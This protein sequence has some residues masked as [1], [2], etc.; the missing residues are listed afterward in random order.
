MLKMRRYLTVLIIVCFASSLL[1]S[2]EFSSVETYESLH[3]TE[4]S[5]S[6]FSV[7]DSSV[8][9]SQET[10]DIYESLPDVNTSEYESSED[11]DPIPEDTV[12]SF[13]AC[14][15]NIIHPSVFYD[16]I[17]RAAKANGTKASYKDLHNAE[18]DF[19]PIYEHVAA[20]IE[21]A[22]IAYI[23]Q[24]TLVG[25][26]SGKIIG[27]PCFNS[28]QAIAD[29]VID[30]G[31]DVVNVAHNHMLDSG[32]TKYLDNCNNVFESKG[33]EVI[34]YYPDSESTKNITVIERE[35]IKVAFLAY[36]YGTNGIKLPS[37]SKAVI[38]YFNKELLKTQVAIA[39][40][41]ADITIVSCHWGVEN[42]YNPNSMQKEYAKYMCELGVD[43]VLG[44]HPHVIQPMGWQIS[45]NGN[46]TLVVY[47][48]GNFVSGMKAAKNML[49]GMLSLNIVKDG[50]TG[51]ISIEAPLFIPTVTHY[52][53]TPG[54]MSNDTGFRDFKI[55]LLEDYTEELAAKHGACIYER[56]HKA[57]LVGGKY[58]KEN[59]LNTLFK[60]I[61]AEFLP[62]S[63][64]QE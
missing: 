53:D 54:K 8:E 23:N 4:T 33:V 10:S 60:Y 15:D 51:E 30:M 39:E 29:T 40:E 62:E 38:P 59:L 36:T 47:S 19:A 25:G 64:V 46:K 22:D 2:C 61:P 3:L 13:L 17:D 26:T 24:E 52:K 63:Y 35:G 11:S 32:N 12:I 31:V 5:N 14:P 41:I 44:M 49:A 28:P 58:S 43:V 27:Y 37:S 20:M 56:T 7:E 6:S 16:A 55:Y 50:E 18:Y 45:E 48:L 9:T 42:S 21:D 34:G 1:A 57:T